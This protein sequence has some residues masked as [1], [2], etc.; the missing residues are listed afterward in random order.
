MMCALKPNLTDAG[1]LVQF[2]EDSRVLALNPFAGFASEPDEI[3]EWLEAVS[4]FS[5]NP[6]QRVVA[7]E[8]GFLVAARGEPTAASLV[9]EWLQISDLAEFAATL[10]SVF[11]LA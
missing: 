1:N 6:L 5:L 11:C 10:R 8:A 2:G 7:A 4:G 3:L 9:A